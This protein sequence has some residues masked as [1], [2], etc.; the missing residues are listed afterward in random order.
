MRPSSKAS[1]EAA[2]SS[3][4]SDDSHPPFGTDMCLT[5]AKLRR[6]SV[7]KSVKKTRG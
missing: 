3:S 1:R 4:P 2:A 6:E 5:V 7:I